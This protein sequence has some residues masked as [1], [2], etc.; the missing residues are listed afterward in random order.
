[1]KRAVILILSRAIHILSQLR[2]RLDPKRAA[3]PKVSG[4]LK[5]MD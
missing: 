3:N 4:T 2:N 5:D 1:M